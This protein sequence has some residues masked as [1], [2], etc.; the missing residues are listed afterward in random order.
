MPISTSP[1][2][3]AVEYRYFVCDLLTNNLL[4]EMPF[5]S[6]SYSRSLVEAGSFEGDL[7]VIDDTYNLDVYNSTLPGKT[8]LYIVRNGVCVWGGIIWGRTYSLIDKVVSVSALEFPSYFAHRVV[9]KTW[10]TAYEAV[11]E[12]S[13]GVATVT[14]TGGEYDFQVNDVVW[15]DWGTEY[16]KYTGYFNIDSVSSTVDSRS[17]FTA[18]ATYIDSSNSEKVMPNMTMGEDNPI[19]VETR[20]DTYQYARDLLEELNTDL[21]DFDFANDEIRPGVDYFNDIASV[22]RDSNNISTI[23]LSNTHELTVGQKIEISDVQTDADFNTKEAKVLEIVSD[24]T[25]RYIN[26]GSEVSTTAETDYVYGVVSFSRQS[27][28]STYTTDSNHNLSANDIIFVE[29]VSETFDGYY[30]VY[31]TPTANSF[32][33]VTFGEDIALSY[34]SVYAETNITNAVGDGISVTF[35]ANNDF[36]VGAPVEVSNVVPSSF[37]GSYYVES[38]TDTT[39]TVAD[40]NTDTYTSGGLAESYPPT[41]KRRAAVTYGTFGE[42]TVSGDLSIT[43][44]QSASGKYEANPIIRGYELKT[45]YEIL[46]EYSTKPDGFEYRIDCEFDDS[47]KTFT[48]KFKFLPLVPDALTSWLATQ[49]DGYSGPIPASAYGADQL[50]FEYPGNILEAQFDES[51][52]DAATRFFVQ[53]K[54]STL[55]AD[56]SQ[57]YSAAS[58]HTLLNDGWALLDAVDDLDSFQENVLYKQASRLLAES[59]PPVS[60]FTISVNGSGRPTL[61]DYSPGDWCVLKLNDPFVE[62]RALSS[63]EQ[64]YGTDQGVLIRKILAFEVSVPDTPSYPEEVD[65]ELVIEPSI[66]ISGVTVVNGKAFL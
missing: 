57:P 13:D 6:V 49:A 2:N 22:A 48:R 31:D 19:T 10:N 26:V 61:G 58:N 46:E 16:A 37:N 30:L 65:L 64:D 4:A 54:D 17:I 34:T 15:L 28:I 12:V 50:V 1:S 60:T 42:H 14:L 7:P 5:K 56:A 32:R 52:E 24:N 29:N 47:T 59:T 39:F 11:A 62:Q 20:Q 36:I 51:A 8:A 21:F 18:P 63:L 25:F 27:N 38:R 33:A 41:V 53:G 35:T 9:W 66:P 45:V 40:S 23:T 43:F 3:E 55:S 44:T